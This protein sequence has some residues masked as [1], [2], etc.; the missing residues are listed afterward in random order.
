[1]N[2]LREKSKEQT[3]DEAIAVLREKVTETDWQIIRAVNAR[4]EL[5]KKIGTLKIEAGLPI[6]DEKREGELKRAHADQ[7]ATVGLPKELVFRIFEVILEESKRIQKTSEVSG[8]AEVS[9]A[10]T[11]NA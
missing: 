3:L 2:N 10:D 1:M 11:S 5:A 9:G 6:E 8:G 4:M 7:A